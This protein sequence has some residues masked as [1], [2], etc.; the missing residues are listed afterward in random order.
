MPP[1]ELKLSIV[2]PMRDE[3]ECVPILIE[4]LEKA[5]TGRSDWELICVDDG[6]ADD[7]WLRI[8]DAAQS[9]PWLRGIRLVRSFGQ[10]PATIAGLTIAHGDVIATMDA[11]LSVAPEDVLKLEQCVDG[12]IDLVFGRRAHAGE[13]FMRA[14]VGPAVTALLARFAV[15][16]PPA[17][18]STFAAAT[19]Q[20]VTR[21]LEFGRERPVVPYHLMLGGP[22]SVRSI[23]VD[24]GARKAGRSKYSVAALIA[25][26][27]DIAFGYTSIPG[28]LLWGS[29][30]AVP[31]GTILLWA[32]AGAASLLRQ[33]G[34]YGILALAGFVFAFAGFVWM[35]FLV[36]V[37][38][39]RFGYDGRGPLYLVRESF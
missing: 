33:Q 8:R 20:V 1:G 14:R 28:A 19:R 31:A 16:R 2:I 22:R 17:G 25:L 39:L 15:G 27:A 23:A 13:G 37:I 10:H 4:R 38:A 9:R 26:S 3:A 11:D 34:L 30:V 6:S 35:L 18:I 24:E 5:L 12:G 29:A 32:L 7:T 36:G 21:A